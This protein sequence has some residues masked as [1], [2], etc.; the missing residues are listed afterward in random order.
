MAN[1]KNVLFTVVAMVAVVCMSVSFVSCNSSDEGLGIDWNTTQKYPTPSGDSI[2]VDFGLKHNWSPENLSVLTDTISVSA[3][4]TMGSKRETASETENLKAELSEDS[5]NYFIVE[6]QREVKAISHV[7]TDRSRYAQWEQK[8]CDIALNDGNVLHIDVDI[9]SKTYSI[10]NNTYDL[11]TLTCDSIKFVKAVNNAPATTRA[12]AVPEYYVS[13]VMNTT[14]Y[15]DVYTHEVR[16]ISNPKNYVKRMAIDATRKLLSKN[17]I[18]KVTDSDKKHEAISETQDRFSFKRTFEYKGGQ[19]V[20]V[21]YSFV[22]PREFKGKTFSDR[23]TRDF[24][25]NWKKD[26]GYVRGTS[27]TQIETSDKNW[28]CW[29][30]T[31]ASGA[32]VANSVDTWTTSYTYTIPRATFEDE[33]GK[34]EFD[35][36]RPEV[37]EAGTSVSNVT[38]DGNYKRATVLNK[39]NTLY[40]GFSQPLSET[41][42]LYQAEVKV[43][44]VKYNITWEVKNGYY[45]AHAVKTTT[46][47]DGNVVN[48]PLEDLVKPWSVTAQPGWESRESNA[49]QTTS[50]LSSAK[51]S[52]SEKKS[53]GNWRYYNVVYRASDNAKLNANTKNNVFNI[54]VIQGVVFVDDEGKE[55][56]LTD[57]Q[58]SVSAGGANVT[59]TNTTETLDT[60]QYSDKINVN[61]GGDNKSATAYGTIYVTKEQ[62]WNPDINMHFKSMSVTNAP[63]ENNASYNVTLSVHFEEGTWLIVLDKNANSIGKFEEGAR[64]VFT[65]DT[66]AALNGGAYKKGAWMHT[67]ASDEG[68]YMLWKASNG[69]SVRSLNYISATAMDWYTYGNKITVHNHDYS[70]KFENNVLTIMKGNTVLGTYK[71]AK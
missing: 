58:V 12:A 32:N 34:V 7:M 24:A 45:T 68:D 63:D 22:G 30:T 51:S 36:V 44:S 33:Y 40:L 25:W 19:T 9:W 4:A 42:G 50:G 59:K 53:E 28:K 15:V 14:F 47:T 54:N 71:T 48:T 43:K 2:S 49:N 56:A 23:E 16:N 60:Y 39:I 13:E 57:A 66:N 1:V 27:E 37:S 52:S 38:S 46:Y 70:Y 55:H 11:P 69:S 67:V 62:P 31:D 35:Y 10:F 41:L 61:F 20:V 3:T 17:D 21:D 65:S 64:K 26:N 6:S 18:A 5:T 8:H 29:V